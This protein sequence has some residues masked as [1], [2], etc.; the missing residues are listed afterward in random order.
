MSDNPPRRR[1]D[2]ETVLRLLAAN[3]QPV[4]VS[5]PELVADVDGAPLGVSTVESN[6]TLVVALE[7]LGWTQAELDAG[8]Q[9]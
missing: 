1:P 2:R 7:S 8:V 4:T 9:A 6:G 5:E 3:G